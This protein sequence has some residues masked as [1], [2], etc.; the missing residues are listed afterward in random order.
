[1][2][3]LIQAVSAYG[4]RVEQTH[5]VQASQ[6]A[7]Y[8]S[9]RTSLNRGEIENVL[10][11]LNEAISFFARQ[12]SSVKLEGV[13]IFRPII[14][15]SG[16]LGIGFRL[17]TSINKALNVPGAFTGSVRNGEN[18]G[19]SAEEIKAMWNAENPDDLI[20]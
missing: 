5:T 12:G 20:P 6:M 11:E 19:K 17:D 10:R 18:V 8:I 7:E 16:V 13:G 15:L 1:M 4:P 9:G 14:K 2:A 3:T